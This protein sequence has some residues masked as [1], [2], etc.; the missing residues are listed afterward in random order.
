M[1]RLR[2]LVIG[3]L[4]LLLLGGCSFSNDS[5]AKTDDDLLNQIEE[6]G[7]IIIATEGTWAPWTYHDEGENLIGYDVEVAQ[8]IAK[9]LGVTATFVEGE[10]DGLFAGLDAKRYDVVI[11]GV[12]ITDE[13]KEKYAFS[14]PY[15]YIKTAVIVKGDNRE[16]A[17]FEDLEGKRTANTLASTYAFLA[18]SYGADA[19]GVDD[20]N[21]TIELLL[22]DR[23]DATLNAE[24]TF[25]D[26]MKVHPE[27][28]LKIAALTDESAL[29]AVAIRQGEENQS[30]QTAINQAITELRESGEL[31]KLALKY[32]GKDIA[33]EN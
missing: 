19:I 8:K 1:K 32:F 15:G 18:E 27:A 3:L 31:T 28:N 23:V 25:V 13:R 7:E 26:Y 21:Q 12:E 11:N 6:R 2:I 16:I 5:V 22:A 33:W 20:L 29:I 17:S 9:K 4:G 24:V 30:L 14:E 10:W